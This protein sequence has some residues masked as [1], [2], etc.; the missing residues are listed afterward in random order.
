MYLLYYVLILLYGLL[1][2]SFFNVAGLRI[3]AGESIV[4]P[5]SHCPK[6]G[7]TLGALE[8]IPVLSYVFQGGKC[9]QCKAGISPFYPIIELTTGLLFLFAALMMGWTGEL[10]VALTLISL[11]VIV[12]VSD[13]TYM[14]IP[15]KVLLF[16]LPL[17]IVER[18]FIPLT[19]WWD[20]LLGAAVGFGLLLLIAVVSKGGMG[21]GDVKLYGVLGIVLGFKFVLLSLFLAV[22]FGAFFG[23]IGMLFGK[24]KKGKAIPFGPYICLAVLITYFYGERILEWYFQLFII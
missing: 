1:L 6:C 4:K 13:Y 3:P 19:P 24:V 16:F 14:I 15:D 8:L 7:H 17:F 9:R 11:C 18:I 20:S 10:V 2:G 22:F 5:R 23:G 21:G 12:F